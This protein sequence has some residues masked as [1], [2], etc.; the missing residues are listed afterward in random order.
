MWVGCRCET[1]PWEVS[2]WFFLD[3]RGDYTQGFCGRMF[4]GQAG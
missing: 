1:V 3:E 2:R 4:E